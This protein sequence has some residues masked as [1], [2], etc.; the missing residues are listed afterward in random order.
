MGYEGEG[1]MKIYNKSKLIVGFLILIV[2]IYFY[3]IKNW[4]LMIGCISCGTLLI[5]ISFISWMNKP[6]E[7]ESK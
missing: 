5:I 2:S 4:L 6:I 3:Y 1:K 7:E